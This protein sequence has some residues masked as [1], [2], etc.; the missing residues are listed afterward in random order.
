[1]GHDLIDCVED[2]ESL[3][4]EI[5]LE[6]TG[7]LPNARGEAEWEMNTARV[8]FT[9]EIDGV[10]AGFYTLM[11]DGV[12]EGVIEAR[13]MYDGYVYGRIRFSDSAIH[14]TRVL[15]FEP[16]GKVIEVVQGGETILEVLFPEE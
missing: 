7:L 15:D 9:V 5:D 1:M 2:G 3:E 4:I 6:N 12:E 11:V 8:R 10:S 13:E 14:G 16:R